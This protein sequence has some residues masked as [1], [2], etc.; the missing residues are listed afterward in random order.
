[1][2]TETRI[3]YM[4]KTKVSQCGL[5][6][7]IL[8]VQDVESEVASE[9]EKRCFTIRYLSN[10][11]IPADRNYPTTETE[12]LSVVWALNTPCPYVE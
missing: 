3:T 10:T 12:C 4:V 7:V 2:F 1:M 6:E 9:K 5:G 11:L 8:Q